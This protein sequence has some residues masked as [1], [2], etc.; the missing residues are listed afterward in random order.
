MV[1]VIL[2]H[3]IYIQALGQFHAN[4]KHKSLY[5]SAHDAALIGEA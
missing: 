2:V 1:G 5:G 4:R 3:V